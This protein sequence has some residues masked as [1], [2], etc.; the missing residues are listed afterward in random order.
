MG[1]NQG[2]LPTKS[3]K[4]VLVALRDVLWQAVNAVG[5]SD[6]TCLQQ[7]S[8]KHPPINH[9]T[10]NAAEAETSIRLSITPPGK[11]IG[12]NIKSVVD[13]KADT[14]EIE[15]LHSR[16]SETLLLNDHLID[17]MDPVDQPNQVAEYQKL[18]EEET[19]AAMP[20]SSS[21]YSAISLDDAELIPYYSN[22]N[23]ITQDV[24]GVQL[25][26]KSIETQ[27]VIPRHYIGYTTFK[28]NDAISHEGAL[29]QAYEKKLS[30]K[31]GRVPTTAISEVIFSKAKTL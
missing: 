24:Y 10:K 23:T 27:I 28:G 5:R 19:H 13:D 29:L 4:Q 30:E 3:E 17:I 15:H 9:A 12:L 8:I 6:G 16:V 1:N 18:Y 11:T 20:K 31:L 25:D 26:K 14:E 22:Q 7:I 2:D 21:S